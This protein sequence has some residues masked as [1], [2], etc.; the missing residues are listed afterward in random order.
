MGRSVIKMSVSFQW[1]HFWKGLWAFV[2]PTLTSSDSL[3]VSVPLSTL[4]TVF[5][6][7]CLRF[8]NPTLFLTHP[9]SCFFLWVDD[10]YYTDPLSRGVKSHW[11]FV[12]IASYQSNISHSISYWAYYWVFFLRTYQA[13][14]PTELWVEQ[15]TEKLQGTVEAGSRQGLITNLNNV[16]HVGRVPDTSPSRQG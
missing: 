6:R 2:D 13:H 12:L 11:C 8:K 9:A 14:E 15:P 4:Y 10:I 3:S 1:C 5:Y 16:R 7:L